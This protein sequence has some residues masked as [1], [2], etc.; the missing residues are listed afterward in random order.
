MIRSLLCTSIVCLLLPQQTQA[1]DIVDFLRAFSGPSPRAHAGHG[2]QVNHHDHRAVS[3]RPGDR[4]ARLTQAPY[5][6]ASHL[7]GSRVVSPRVVSS[8]VNHRPTRTSGLSFHVSIGNR[9]PVVPRYV[10]TQQLPVGYGASP[11]QV[12]PH[13]GHLPAPPLPGSQL[14]IAPLPSVPVPGQFD[15]LPHQ[16]GQIVTC[17]VPVFTHVHVESA[18]RI[19]PNAVPTLVAV[20][21][22]NLGRFRTCIEQMVY[23]EVLA[24][25]SPPRRVKVSACRTRVRLDYGRYEVTIVS[26]D[27][28]VTVEYDN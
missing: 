2:R 24:P 9:S 20:R 12:A 19:A 22:P 5:G 28:H 23:I 10:P 26:R 4:R 16:L 18:C 14:P 8:G 6:G 3:D 7:H 15:H 25:P 17:S 21:D 27:G 1:N 11:Y 13:G